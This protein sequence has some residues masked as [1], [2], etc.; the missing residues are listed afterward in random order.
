MIYYKQ[1][2]KDKVIIGDA[3]EYCLWNYDKFNFIWASPPC[4]THS[5][6]NHFLH[7]QG[8]RRYPDMKLW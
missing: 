1:F 2:P 8:V 3:Y 6:C 5:I 7:A 4:P